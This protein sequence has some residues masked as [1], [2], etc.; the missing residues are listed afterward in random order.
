MVSAGPVALN[1]GGGGEIM[2]GANGEDSGGGISAAGG[3]S[4]R[5]G[6]VPGREPWLLMLLAEVPLPGRELGAV[7]GRS[8]DCSASSVSSRLVGGGAAGSA[9]GWSPHALRGSAIGRVTP[10]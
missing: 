4:A 8:L 5:S 3:V 10:R 7:P 1:A 2:S 9:A 6:A